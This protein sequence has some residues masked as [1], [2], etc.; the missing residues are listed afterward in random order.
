MSRDKSKLQTN[1]S[2]KRGKLNKHTPKPGSASTLARRKKRLENLIVKLEALAD[3]SNYQERE[4]QR[5]QRLSE[6]KIERKTI[7][8]SIFPCRDVPAQRAWTKISAV[9]KAEKEKFV[10]KRSWWQRYNHPIPEFKYY[11][12][13]PFRFTPRDFSPNGLS[14]GNGLGHFLQ[15]Q[16]T[17]NEVCLIEHEYV[18]EA[19]LVEETIKDRLAALDAEQAILLPEKI[20]YKTVDD[21]PALREELKLCVEH[22]TSI[23]LDEQKLRL[24][25]EVDDVTIAKAAA[26]GEKTRELASRIRPS[27]QSQLSI[28]TNCPYCGDALRDTPHADHIFPVSLGGLSTADNLVLVCSL[29]NS[30]KADL[31]LREFCN[32][33]SL[34]RET[35]EFTLLSMGKRV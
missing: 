29:C 16:D 10:D 32:K 33:F 22:L 5:L 15:T 9:Y 8:E 13:S 25:Y 7:V 31:T 14:S 30:K 28:S 21:L 23:E 17:W 24:L 19:L 12:P 3:C 35:I 26:H 11:L 18:Q 4:R 6:I 34:D 2:S 27:L 1:A 20:S